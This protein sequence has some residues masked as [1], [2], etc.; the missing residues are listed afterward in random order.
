MAD[1]PNGVAE[2]WNIQTVAND[3]QVDA[4]TFIQKHR[5]IKLNGKE[6]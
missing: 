4:S 5:K 2:Y 3:I 1:F 6:C